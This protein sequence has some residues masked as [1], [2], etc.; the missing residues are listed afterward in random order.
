MSYLYVEYKND[1]FK[2]KFWGTL[3]KYYDYFELYHKLK[4]LLYTND[5]NYL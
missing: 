4:P 5:G 2:Q 1:P 3:K